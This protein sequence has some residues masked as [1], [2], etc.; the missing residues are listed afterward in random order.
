MMHFHHCLHLNTITSRVNGMANPV[1]SMC[2]TMIYSWLTSFCTRIACW[3]YSNQRPSAFHF[4]H[5]RSTTIPLA[6]VFSSTI[7]SGTNHFIID[8]N[9][10]AF[11]SMPTFTFTV[12]DERNINNLQCFWSQ[13]WPWFEGTPSWRVRDVLPYP[14]L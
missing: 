13:A 2:N 7:I 5:Q 12:V 6:T 14:C 10:N 11:V 3:D 4:S 9:I 8:H 1:W